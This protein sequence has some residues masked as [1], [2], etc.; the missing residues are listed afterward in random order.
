LHLDAGARDAV[1]A[2]KSL[3]PAGV[4]GVD[5]RFQRGEAVRLCGP[6]GAEIAVGLANYD[7]HEAR[8]IAGLRSGAV[9][10]ALGYRR[11]AAL[12]HAD[13]IVLNARST[14]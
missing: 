6:D 4:T 8:T 3:L 11:G 13:D 9:E 12:V 1:S 5:G 2:G 10:A 14:Q 7:D